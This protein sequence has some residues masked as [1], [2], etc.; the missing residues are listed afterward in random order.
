MCTVA[1]QAE[2]RSVSPKKATN[3]DRRCKVCN[4]SINLNVS[5]CKKC[6]EFFEANFG[7]R[8]VCIDSNKSKACLKDKFS[9]D[10]HY[11]WFL[12]CIREGLR[13]T[14]TNNSF[15]K[16]RFEKKNTYPKISP[17]L[18]K[19]PKF[20]PRV[21]FRY[22][23]V[24]PDVNLSVV[25]REENSVSQDESSG[26]C[27][28]TLSTIPESLQDD[29][30]LDTSIASEPIQDDSL[31]ET[32]A[33]SEYL[34]DDIPESSYTI[35]EYRSNNSLM[36]T[37]IAGDPIQYGS[38][39]DTSIA[40]EYLQDDSLVDTSIVSENV[41]DNLLEST[42]IAPE[43]FQDDS[44]V[45]TSNA[46]EYLQGYSLVDT[47]NVP[48]YFQNDGL[49]NAS[50]ASEYLQSDI[51]MR[52]Y[53]AS[54]YLPDDRH[55]STTNDFEYLQDDSFGNTYNASQHLQDDS[56]ESTS[57]AS[58][59][60]QDDSLESTYDASENLLD[61]SSLSTPIPSDSE[62]DVDDTDEVFESESDVDDLDE[63]VESESDD[64]D[65]DEAV[66]TRE[67]GNDSS[68][69]LVNFLR[70][71]LSEPD[72]QEDE[73][74]TFPFTNLDDHELL[75]QKRRKFRI[76]VDE[77]LDRALASASQSASDNGVITKGNDSKGGVP[78]IKSSFLEE[79]LSCGTWSKETNLG[80]EDWN[81]DSHEP[82]LGTIAPANFSGRFEDNQNDSSYPEQLSRVE[83]E[84]GEIKE[85]MTPEKEELEKLEEEEKVENSKESEFLVE[86]LASDLLDDREVDES[87]GEKKEMASREDW[88]EESH[89]LDLGTIAT[90]D[91]DALLEVDQKILSYPEKLSRGFLVDEGVQE[92]MALG[93]K[94]NAK[95]FDD[96]AQAL[97]SECQLVDERE[98]NELK[99]VV[100]MEEIDREEEEQRLGSIA[101]AD[102]DVRFED[103]QKNLSCSEQLSKGVLVEHGSQ[104]SKA[105]EEEEL[106]KMENEEGKAKDFE[107]LAQALAS[108]SQLVDDRVVYELKNVVEKEEIDGEEKKMPS[109]EDL[110]EE[111]HGLDLG[112]I[113]TEDSGFEDDQDN[114]TNP[115]VLVED[116]V[117][118]YVA[119]EKE[120][121]EILQ[122][123][124]TE[125]FE[126]LE[127]LAKRAEEELM[128]ENLLKK[129]KIMIMEE[130]LNPTIPEPRKRKR[131]S[132]NKKKQTTIQ[133]KGNTRDTWKMRS[134]SNT[135]RKAQ[136]GHKVYKIE[137]EV[138]INSGARPEKRKREYDSELEDE[139]YDP[140]KSQ[141]ARKKQHVKKK[142]T[143]DLRRIEEI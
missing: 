141:Q 118:E 62:S 28:T 123:E 29:S 74:E 22:Q 114:S 65:K 39:V 88:N 63:I 99:E 53:R 21:P 135:R 98:T 137:D 90:T 49:V 16:N 117:Q 76:R 127:A 101:P 38:L 60:F 126:A 142:K 55:V 7:K 108:E 132:K 12:K 94:E 40:S 19:R 86:A 2:V 64:D 24:S 80:G 91:S 4:V 20:L 45:S 140:E 122:K 97:A 57:I 69:W 136:E 92:S 11:C 25:T 59:Y 52:N 112:T 35:P 73:A 26:E 77:C 95:E 37:F 125:N 79:E 67:N 89:E 13:R 119:L 6:K 131:I 15:K 51:L 9:R 71:A 139:D 34:Q 44:L 107:G 68:T 23:P 138:S 82:A 124:K 113:A 103:N 41:Q 56:F 106:E 93:N 105:L 72:E 31:V 17:H 50:I 87:D 48:E 61:D 100:E 5:S 36:S 75:D 133:A 104:E 14:R 54:E 81:E 42:Y 85:S 58:K 78:V 129:I 83:L 128:S 110:H 130:K 120:E 43:Y 30:L 143:N 116:D 27:Q 66:D 111:N 47:Y 84:E 8:L 134:S 3:K 70:E 10:C 96:L 102:S 1:K 18:A 46:F 32:S 109:H 115:D 121:L 33:A